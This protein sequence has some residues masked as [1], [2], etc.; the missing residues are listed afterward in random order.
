MEASM[1]VARPRAASAELMTAEHFDTT[2]RLAVALAQS[3][4]FKDAL[5]ETQAFAKI[6]MGRDL[7]LSPIQSLMGLD[8]VKGNLQIRGVLLASFIRQS[9]DYHYKV[10]E[11]SHT[12][13]KV[14]FLGY[15]QEEAEDG[16]YKSAGRWWEVL[17]EEEFTVEDANRAGLVKTD[18]N[19]EKYPKNMCVWRCLSNG[20]KFHMPELM[21]GVPIYTEAD[22]F[23]LLEEGPHG[24]DDPNVIR[25][26][27]MSLDA[28]DGVR[29]RL[30]S[31]VEQANAIAP[32]SFGLGKAQITL[33]GRDEAGLV[34][35][36]VAIERQNA[37]IL[38]RQPPSAPTPTPA[39][40]EDIPEAHVIGDWPDWR[41][42]DDVETV[43]A[44]LQELYDAR[45][46]LEEPDD[47]MERAIQGGVV[48][49]GELQ[50]AAAVDGEPADGD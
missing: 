34:E 46:K 10:V 32:G 44:L 40:P 43:H 9:V 19:W 6:L 17:G 47:E 12:A 22:D 28:P 8:I 13:A 23:G 5:Q 7:G 18:S 45:S 26:F 42:A 25:D 15:P 24:V 29:Q 11:K 20:V 4:M 1:A 14:I 16:F 38:R 41:A 27:V 35:Q 49:L 36:A 39:T 31:A 30:W 2:W 50:D 37:E 3:R 21:G 48:R 33:A